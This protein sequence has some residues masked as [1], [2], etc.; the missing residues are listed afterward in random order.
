MFSGQLFDAEDLMRYSHGT[1]FCLNMM[2]QKQ[3]RKTYGDGVMFVA[4]AGF[5]TLAFK[6][7]EMF[8]NCSRKEISARI[9]LALFCCVQIY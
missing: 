8:S 5:S 7:P 1:S 6:V 3:I 2:T 9:V 4:V